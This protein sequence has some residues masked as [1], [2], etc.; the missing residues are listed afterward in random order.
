MREE[1]RRRREEERQRGQNSR[2]VFGRPNSAGPVTIRRPLQAQAQPQPQ[3]QKMDMPK[4]GAQQSQSTQ[5][6]GGGWGSDVAEIKPISYAKEQEAEAAQQ[7]ARGFN[8]SGSVDAP[9]E[10]P[11]RSND[12]LASLL[13]TPQLDTLDQRRYRPQRHNERTGR[14]QYGRSWDSRNQDP[15]GSPEDVD[16]A[17]PPTPQFPTANAS[18]PRYESADLFTRPHTPQRLPYQNR[19]RS[20]SYPSEDEGG[21]R[22]T[23]VTASDYRPPNASRYDESQADSWQHLSRRRTQSDPPPPPPS[24]AQPRNQ[25]RRQPFDDPE[26]LER[27]FSTLR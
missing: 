12:P 6:V 2:G 11:Q 23:P 13:D 1:E 7:R 26:A 27:N 22:A 9:P 5:S 18:R 17:L 8:K 21:Y 3:M 24:P 19:T 16:D 4:F 20:N 15:F 14:G 25:P 10:P